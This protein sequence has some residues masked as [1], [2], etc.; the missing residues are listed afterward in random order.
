MDQNRER[1]GRHHI[2]SKTVSEID[3]TVQNRGRAAESRFVRKP[4]EKQTKSHGHVTLNARSVSSKN[5]RKNDETIGGHCVLTPA[6]FVQKPLPRGRNGGI[7]G[8]GSPGPGFVSIVLWEQYG[9]VIP[10]R[11]DSGNRRK[12]HELLRLEAQ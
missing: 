4:M 8:V 10:Y 1:Y 2:S 3:E 6:S 9:F 7:M 12:T 11:L 5:V